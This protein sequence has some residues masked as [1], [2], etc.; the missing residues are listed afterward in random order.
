MSCQ[1]RAESV[2]NEGIG[3]LMAGFLKATDFD[4]SAA[5]FADVRASCGT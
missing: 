5:A 3:L 4:N 2:L 1:D